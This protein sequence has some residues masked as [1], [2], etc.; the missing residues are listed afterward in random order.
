MPALIK[1]LHKNNRVEEIDCLN[2]MTLGRDKSSTVHL[3]DPMA[4]RNHGVIRAVGKDQYYLLDTG[5]RNGI[6]LNN[7][8]IS[9]PMLLKDGDNLTIGDTIINF[10]QE[11]IENASLEDTLENTAPDFAETMHYV[12]ADIRAVIV[13]VSDIRGFTS[14]SESLPIESLTK[15]MSF[16]FQEVQNLVED[17]NGIVDKFIGDCVLAKWE[18]EKDDKQSLVQALNT[19]LNLHKITDRLGKKF[20]EIGRPL[21]IGVGLNKGD[22]AFGIGAENTIMG[23]VVNTA[24][25]LETASKQLE[26]DIVMNS[27]FYNDLPS[28]VPISETQELEVKGKTELLKVTT[29]GFDDLAEFI[30]QNA[31]VYNL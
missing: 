4:S 10:N 8:R 29:L 12:K 3:K 30:Q 25:R 27:S 16:W 6:Y 24:F 9:A 11:Y 19:A 5:S 15:L 26:S 14:I 20:P 28:N 23:D 21:Q 7:R 17:N 22:A 1:I 2:I 18:V 31:E 13:L